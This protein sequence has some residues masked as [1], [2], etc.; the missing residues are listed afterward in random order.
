MEPVLDLHCGLGEA[1]YH[2]T[3]TNTLR[4]V[5]IKKHRLHTL[6][7][8]KP[9][10]DPSALTTL[11]L[12]MPIG[13]TADIDGVDPSKKILAGGKTGLAVLDRET[14]KYEMITRFY[15]SRTGDERLRSND[16]TVDAKGRFWIGT[17]NDFNVGEPQAEGTLFRFD[18]DLSR[19]AMRDSLTI[20]NG[21]G[22][23]HDQKTMYFTHSTENNLYA[24]DF[25]PETG[26]ISNPRVY[27][28]H[29][30]DGDPDGWKMDS[31][32]NIWHAVYSEGKVLKISTKKPEKGELVG[33]IEVPTRNVTCPCF[34]GEELWVT[35]AEEDEPEKYPESAKH[36]GGVFKVHLGVTGTKEYKFK[37]DAEATRKAG[38][39]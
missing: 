33:E 13:V 14:G 26:A 5:D 38:L 7:L 28:H 15:D 22:W 20:P 31:E 23:S 4:F 39:S 17:M 36:G 8:S 19:H 24:Y 12:D 21:I 25:S 3:N 32:G 16:G 2:E 18:S 1:P 11:Q 9:P 35:S 6:D 10:N 29:N 30:G 34:V 27:Y 37:M